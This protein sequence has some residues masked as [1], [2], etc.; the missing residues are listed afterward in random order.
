MWVS[1][2]TPTFTT[3]RSRSPLCPTNVTFSSAAPPFPVCCHSPR[4]SEADSGG[5]HLGVAPDQGRDWP[6]KDHTE[7][8]TSPAIER[9][10]NVNGLLGSQKGSYCPPNLK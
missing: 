2:S 1:A 9:R 8:Y 6:V 5:T 3:W 10:E 7:K 4:Y